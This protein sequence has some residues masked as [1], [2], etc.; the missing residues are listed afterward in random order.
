MFQPRG[1]IVNYVIGLFGIRGPGWLG[2]PEWSK[3]ALILM[4][5]WSVEEKSTNLL[6]ERFFG[7]LKEGMGKLEAL[8]RARSDIRAA[9]YEHPYYWAPFILV[10]ES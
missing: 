3:P 8:R 7:Y 1:G 4:S 10:G 2:S 6:T 5:L 9:G